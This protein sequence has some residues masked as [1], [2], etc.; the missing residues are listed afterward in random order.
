[1]RRVRRVVGVAVIAAALPLS[2][3]AAM[4]GGYDLAPNGLPVAE[5][6]LRRDLAARPSDAYLAVV[7]GR[8]ELPDDDLLRLLYAGTAGRYAGAYDEGAHLLDLASWI[9]EDR[10]T[11]SISRQA[12]SLITSDRALDYVPGGTER[13]MIPYL[14]ATT[15]LE[16]GNTRAAAVEARRIE[17]LLDRM[18]DRDRDGP[19]GDVDPTRR[20]LHTFAASV[21]EAAGDRSAADV[22]YRRAGVPDEAGDDPVAVVTGTNGSPPGAVEPVTLEPAAL[23]PAEPGGEVVVLVESG[24]VPHRVEQ[25]VVI[26]LPPWQVSLLTEGSAAE[27]A[28]AATEAAARVLLSADHYYGDRGTYGDQGYPRDGRSR[29]S[30]HFSPW[31]REDCEEAGVEDCSD[32]ADE[33]PYLMRISWPVLADEVRTARPVR[34]RAGDLAGDAVVRFDV[35]AG[36]RNDFD[37]SRGTMIARTMLRAA[38]KVALSSAAKVAVEKKDEIAG[39]LLGVLTNLGTALTE[40]A[41]T[42]CWHLLPGEV[43]MLRLRLPAGSHELM[44]ELDDTSGSTRAVSLGSVDVVPGRT[45][46]VTHRIW[47]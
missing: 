46:F 13:L 36:S 33:N 16:A 14:A 41:D 5:D 44:L 18:A 27:K 22:A 42:R 15:Y 38:S 4:F 26:V 45:A 1:M 37:D 28:V 8:R 39:R 12:L 7:E 19:P 6:A 21:F 43:S 30:V 29:S 34:V 3:C 2:G 17:A 25:S 47:N 23:E 31:T 35:A 24:F 11:T 20:F 10:V 9:A 40:R 32:S